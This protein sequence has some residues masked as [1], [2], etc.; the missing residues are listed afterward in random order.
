MI[1]LYSR[2]IIGWACS[3]SPD[4]EL[5]KKALRIAYEARG[6]PKGVSFHSD[7]G[8][9]YISI[10]FQQQLWRFKIKQ[11]MSRRGNCWDNSPM[12]RVFRRFKS[13]WMP[14]EYY[15]SYEAAEKDIMQ[16]ITYYN[17]DRLHSYNDYL[18]PVD[19]EKN[20]A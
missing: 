15:S 6:C 19:A 17:E 12:E 4:S 18:T 16:Y 5:T 11:S 10:A 8:C 14:K 2:R 3:K 20:R 13:E 1:D 9:H 7:Q